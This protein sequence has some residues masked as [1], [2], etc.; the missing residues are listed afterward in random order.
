MNP[1]IVGT[2]G[3]SY[4]V[5]IDCRTITSKNKLQSAASNYERAQQINLYYNR[6]QVF[7]RNSISSR[8]YG[9]AFVPLAK[10]GVNLLKCVLKINVSRRSIKVLQLIA[11][12]V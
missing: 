1:L 9:D 7:V 5:S 12:F 10:Y 2:I 8:R 4:T 6:E 3:H 11:L